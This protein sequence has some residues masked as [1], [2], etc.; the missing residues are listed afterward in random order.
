MALFNTGST[1]K[2]VASQIRNV[3][4]KNKYQES[5]NPSQLSFGPFS[6]FCELSHVNFT[7]RKYSIDY[8]KI[9]NFNQSQTFRGGPSEG[10]LRRRSY[11]NL[12]YES[13][14][15]KCFIFGYCGCC[16]CWSTRY[17]AEEWKDAFSKFQQ[18]K[19]FHGQ[20]VPTAYD[21][22]LLSDWEGVDEITSEKM[23]KLMKLINF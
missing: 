18:R 6:E 1:F 13:R 9:E 2:G 19:H 8:K 7:G 15:K 10:N 16:G 17:T 12:N 14:Q 20:P 22:A 3:I 21:Q 23:I 5:S 11:P 4:N